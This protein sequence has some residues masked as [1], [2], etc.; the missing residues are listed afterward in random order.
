MNPQYDYQGKVAFV[1]GAGDGL[2]RA[3]AIAFAKAGASVAVVG[4]SED[5]THQTVEMIEKD[6]GKAIA[7]LCDVSVESQVKSAVDKTVEAFG[8]L[9]YAYNNAGV[10]P[11]GKPL[12]ELES[13]TFE[14]NVA[15]NLHGV[16]YCMKHQIPHMLKNKGSA[17]VNASSGAGTKG[18]PAHADYCSSKFGVIGLTK[19][20]A[21]DYADKGLRINALCPG[22]IDTPMIKRATGGTE[23]GYAG[24][25]S[26][27]PIGR[28][29]YPEEIANTVLWLC[30]EGAGFAVGSAFTVDGGQTC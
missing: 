17:I 1:T 10:M 11:A 21:L 23:E 3:A 24:A 25:R 16:F 22:I 12:A 26:Q 29:G 5:N 9:D 27:E 19:S 6:G 13:E 30:S 14:K 20:A 4:R 28:L 8:R 2:G 7:I 18:F 15:V